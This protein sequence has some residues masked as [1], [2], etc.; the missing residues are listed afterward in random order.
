MPSHSR[1]AMRPSFSNNYPHQRT[2]GAG[3]AGC[4]LAPMVR[5]QQKSTRRRLASSQGEAPAS[6][7][8]DHTLS[9]SASCC[10]SDD[11]TR[12]SHP[13]PNVR[14]DREAPLLWVRDARMIVLICPTRQHPSGCDT[15]ARRAICAWRACAPLFPLVI[16]GLRLTARPG[17][18]VER[19]R[20]SQ[21]V[22]GRHSGAMFPR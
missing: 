16:P 20:R 9:P 19:S 11:T 15:L 13:A 5:V 2:E 21:H 22:L 17:M 6:G 14:D 7:R 4:R 1:G 8:Q 10:S 3:K 12:P 18:T